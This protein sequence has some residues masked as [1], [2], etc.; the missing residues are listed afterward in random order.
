MRTA[1]LLVVLLAV[2]AADLTKPLPLRDG[3]AG[4]VRAEAERVIELV[5]EQFGKYTAPHPDEWKGLVSP[6]L[7]DKCV[8]LVQDYR[9]G[10]RDEVLRVAEV[11]SLIRL[12]RKGYDAEQTAIYHAMEVHL[13]LQE[14]PDETELCVAVA[15]TIRQY[16]DNV[17]L[18][19]QGY[20]NR[21]AESAASDRNFR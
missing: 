16:Y 7:I 20:W 18:T 14:R 21:R 6:P 1:C 3:C 4:L 11:G 15:A 10:N 13:A 19:V 5:H 17:L 12:P 9:S 8:Q 2:V